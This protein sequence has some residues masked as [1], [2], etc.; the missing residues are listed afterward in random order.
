L[1]H[2]FLIIQIYTTFKLDDKP[3]HFKAQVLNR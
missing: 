1:K 3:A 2:K